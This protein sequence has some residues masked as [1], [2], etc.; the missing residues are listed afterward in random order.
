MNFSE[1]A[2][3][4]LPEFRVTHSSEEVGD[5]LALVLAV[6]LDLKSINLLKNFGLLVEEELESNLLLFLL[7]LGRSLDLLGFV[8]SPSLKLVVEDLEVLALLGVHASLDLLL[9][10]DLFLIAEVSLL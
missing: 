1:S 4:S 9:V 2:I 5:L 10:L 7:E 6:S 3:S 8:Q